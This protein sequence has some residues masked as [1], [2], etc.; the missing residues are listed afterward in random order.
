MERVRVRSANQISGSRM[1]PCGRS[2]RKI[3]GFSVFPRLQ[4]LGRTFDL[5][6]ILCPVIGII[7]VCNCPIDGEISIQRSVRVRL[8]FANNMKCFHRG[9]VII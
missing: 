3:I 5:A 6:I 4:R 8:L 2:F 7:L 9:F 1:L